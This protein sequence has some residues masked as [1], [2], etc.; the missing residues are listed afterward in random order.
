VL[1]QYLPDQRRYVQ[2]A[3]LGAIQSGE[4]VPQA[5]ACAVGRLISSKCWP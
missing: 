4:C 5:S 3:C 1:Q 2:P